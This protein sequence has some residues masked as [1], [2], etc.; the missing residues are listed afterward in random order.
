VRRRC[1]S[2]AAAIDG[3]EVRPAHR[4]G[5]RVPTVPAVIRQTPRL[6]C[7]MMSVSDLAVASMQQPLPVG[8]DASGGSGRRLI[9]WVMVRRR[10]LGAV[11][12]EL[13]VAIVVEPVFFRLLSDDPGMS[14]HFGV[15]GGVLAGRVVAAPD[16]A[17][18][19]APAQVK[20]PSALLF[21]FHAARTSGRDIGVDARILRHLLHETRQE[22]R[23]HSRRGNRPAPTPAESYSR[24]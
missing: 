11:V 2:L 12:V 5:Q 21:T 13:L 6:G 7:R 18:L 24:P 15:D 16:V 10:K 3:F 14:G 4:R 8:R 1:S 20:P 23:A 17:A 9:Q 22:A 19:R